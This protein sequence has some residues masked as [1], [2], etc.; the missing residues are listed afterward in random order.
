MNREQEFL[1]E[2]N[3]FERVEFENGD[4][5]ERI[6]M[7]AGVIPENRKKGDRF[8]NNVWRFYV[9]VNAA[10]R[11]LIEEGT[12]SNV[13]TLEIPLIL[14]QIALIDNPEYKNP[15][16]F[17]AGY[18]ATKGG[19]VNIKELNAIASRVQ[20]S[21]GELKATDILRYARLWLASNEKLKG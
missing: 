3:V 10:A 11:R 5:L 21:T 12:I 8:D 17:I 6:A 1:P 14:R 15:D 7:D 18:A 16:A 20:K 2:V 19:K 13:K 9:Y 4:S